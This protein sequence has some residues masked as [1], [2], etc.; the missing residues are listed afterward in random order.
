MTPRSLSAARR[1]AWMPR[2]LSPE[3]HG[4][5]AARLSPLKHANL[6]VLGRCGFR[7][8]TPAGD[9][10]RPLR[11][12]AGVEPDDGTAEPVDVGP[13]PKELKITLEK[14]RFTAWYLKKLNVQMNDER[15]AER[16]G[17]AW[18]GRN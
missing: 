15:V 7:A 13:A 3:G 2:R 8:S 6:D 4:E 11:D 5:V 18:T 10:P 12:P 9:G 14:S 16:R 1:R 17:P